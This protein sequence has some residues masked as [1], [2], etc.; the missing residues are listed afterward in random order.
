LWLVAALGLV[1]GAC[2]STPLRPSADEA[3]T[4]QMIDDARAAGAEA[5]SPYEFFS[6]LVYF[7]RA[8]AEKADGSLDTAQ[9]L[10]GVAHEKA[11]QALEN[12]RQFRKHE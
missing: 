8:L 5:K 1:L 7:E 9:T 6:A 4:R 11:R 12:A 3:D 2:A 10:F